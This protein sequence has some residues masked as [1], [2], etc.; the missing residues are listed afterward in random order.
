MDKA[1]LEKFLKASEE[2]VRRA[3]AAI[4]EVTS[5]DMDVR[6]KSDG[7]P[8][9]RADTVSGK[10][11]QEGLEKLEP[12]FEIVSEEGEPEEKA[13]EELE[14]YWLVDP[15]DGTKEFVKGLGDYTV[16]IALVEK[17]TPVLGVIYV[18]VSGVL[19][20]AAEGF[21]VFKAEKDSNSQRI[22][23]SRAGRFYKAVVSRSHL[24]EKT[25]SFLLR[26]NIKDVLRHGSSLKMC[27]VAEGSAELYPRF[28][29]TCLWDTGAGCAIAREAD[30][31][32]VDL[33]NRPLRYDL[34]G[35]IKQHGFM[36]YPKKLKSLIKE[37]LESE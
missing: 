19:Y 34:A 10:I 7:S 1:I 28:G 27:A 24:D 2:I 35:G 12:V 11:I 5:G 20:F 17:G 30:C 21:G 33:E 15:L 13:G 29:P 4:L 36:V 37:G 9:T 18:P 3:G 23:C 14:V 8:L 31:C 22:F 32:V 26:M 6:Y 16:N 25:E